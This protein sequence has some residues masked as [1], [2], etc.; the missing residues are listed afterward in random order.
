MRPLEGILVLEFAQ[1]LAAP[2]AAMRLADLGAR[3]I[4]I[5]PGAGDSSR[6]LSLSDLWLDG[7][8]VLFHAINR[9]KQSYSANLK[10]V[11]DLNKVKQ[12]IAQA[13]VL[14]ENFRPGTM[15]R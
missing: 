15:K 6:K 2:S 5:E 14:I 9:N 13:D 1:Y 11:N 12:L 4:K 8:S 7:D 3:V 10:D